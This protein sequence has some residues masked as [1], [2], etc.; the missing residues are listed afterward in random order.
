MNIEPKLQAIEKEFLDIE[1]RMGDPATVSD[2][3]ALQDLEKKQTQLEPVVEK[4][5]AYRAAV[6][7]IAE[8]RDLLKNND[9]EITELA[10]KE[11]SELEPQIENFEKELTI[12]L[13]PKDPV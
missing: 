1:E 4:Y 7:S 3:R 12:L 2:P 6:A 11:L 10:R 13:L 5:R 8:A 9:P